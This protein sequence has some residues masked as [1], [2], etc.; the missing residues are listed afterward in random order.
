MKRELVFIYQEPQII[1]QRAACGLRA[2]GWPPLAN[3]I[4]GHPVL[5]NVLIIL[6]R[7]HVYSIYMI[8]TTNKDCLIDI[9]LE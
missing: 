4:V 5:K 3:N 7:K 9:H 6:C 2:A 1:L 8:F